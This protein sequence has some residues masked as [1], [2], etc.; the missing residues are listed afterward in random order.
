[1]EINFVEEIENLLKEFTDVEKINILKKALL[2]EMTSRDIYQI[3]KFVIDK[4]AF[5]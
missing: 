4:K 3:I 2:M 5:E 1:M